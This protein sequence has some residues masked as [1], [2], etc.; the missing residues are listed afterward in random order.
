VIAEAV[1]EHERAESRLSDARW[2]LAAAAA[3]A[4]AACLEFVTGR[5]THGVVMAAMF[6]GYAIAAVVS[7]RRAGRHEQRAATLRGHAAGMREVADALKG[8][9]C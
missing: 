5:D 8:G 6:V 9:G 4:L 1:A 7:G 2:R 3:S